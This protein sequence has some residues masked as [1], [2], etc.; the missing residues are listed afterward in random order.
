[1]NMYMFTVCIT[2]IKKGKSLS[3]IPCIKV[4]KC[5][6]HDKLFISVHNHDFKI[7]SNQSDYTFIIA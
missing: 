5:G 6:I 2:L 3:F 7:P 1:M 4:H